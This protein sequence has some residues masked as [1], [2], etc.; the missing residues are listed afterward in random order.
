MP[1]KGTPPT[2]HFA[3]FE[4]ARGKDGY[5]RTGSDKKNTSLKRSQIGIDSR[6]LVN[7]GSAERVIQVGACATPWGEQQMPDDP[8]VPDPERI[9]TQADFGRELTALRER[10]GLKIR[11]V[12]KAAK[13]PVSTVGDYFSGR[14]L[15]ADRQT[16]LRILQVCGE[17]DAGRIAQWEAALA[18][19]RRPPGRRTNNPY[20]GLARFEPEDAGRFFGREDVTELLVSL[21]AESSTVPLMLVGPSGAGKSSLLRAGLLPRLKALAEAAPGIAGPVTVFEP[22]AAPLEDLKVHLAELGPDGDDAGRPAVIVD[23]FEAVFTLCADEAQRRDFVSELCDLA[24]STLVVLALRADFYDHAIRYPGLA[25]ALQSR[26]VV[27]GPMTAEQVHR[28]VTEPARLARVTA[29]DGLVGLL[30]ADL[31]PQGAA[32]AYEPGALPLLSHAMMATWEHSRGGTLAIADYLASGGIKDALTQTAERAYGSLSAEQQQLARRLFLR[33]VH[34]ADDLPPSRAT[35]ELGELREWGGRTDGDAERVL[36]TFVGERMITVDAGTAQISHDALLTA[37]PRLRSWIDSGMEGL[38]TRRRITQGARTWD[39]TGRES[40]ALW[41]G[42]QL[43]IAREWTADEHNRSSLPA[44]AAE[45]VDASIAEEGVR[46]HAER[47]RARRLQAVVAMLS[48][49]LVVVAGLVVYVFQQR[50]AVTNAQHLTSAGEGALE[51]DQIRGQDPSLAAQLSVSVYGLVHTEFATTSLLESS[52]APSAARIVD[53]TG[54]VQWA[55]LSPDHKMLAAAGADGTLRLWDVASPGHPFLV[56]NLVAA[57]ADDPLYVTAFSPDGKVLAAAGAG[58]VVN[59]WDMSDPARPRPLGTLTG[60]KNTIYSVAFSPDGTTL[61]AASADGTVRLWD[62]SDPAHAEPLGR[63]LAVSAASGYVE[64]VQFSPDGET[65]AAGTG[66][67]NVWLWNVTSLAHPV[68][69][70]GMPLTGPTMQVSGVAFSPDGRLLAVSSQ[71]KKVWLWRLGAGGLGGAGS[72]GSAVPDGTLTGA[73]NWVDAVAFSPDGRSLAAG[74]SDA[75]VLVWNV[76]TR[77]VSQ[78]LPAAQPVT[79]VTWDGPERIVSTDAE[80]T[81]LLWSLPTPVLATDNAPSSVAYSPDGK[82]LAVG[83][84]NVQIWNTASRELVATHQLPANVFVNGLAYSPNGAVIASAYN[85]G[86]TAL[87]DAKTLAPLGTP[88]TVT[89]FGNAE[90]VAFSPDGK[91]LAT[92]AD[93]GTVRLWSVT[94][95]ARPREL[96]SVRDSGTYVYTVE[97]APDGKTLAAASTDNYTRLWNVANPADPVR[98]GK[99]L[100]GFTSYAIGVAFSPDSRT[101]AIGSADKT[102]RLWNVSDPALPSLIGA[103]LTGPTGYVWGLAFSPDGSTLAA[104]ITDGSVWLWNVSDPA[105]PTPLANLAGPAGHVYSV[106]FAPAGGQLAAS[107]DDGTVHLWDVSPAAARAEACGNLGQPLTRTEWAA[108]VPG[109]PYRAPCS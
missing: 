83:G 23:Q 40:A 107:S 57:N 10:A 6:F 35:V 7:F 42:S 79:S 88:F 22:T 94:D 67:G 21:A 89:K 93:D 30:L 76:A 33:L 3:R 60:A 28:A 38:R 96:K 105:S 53:S 31:A 102:I 50:Q 91:T 39:H 27:L 87:L 86:T 29:E 98:L 103:P 20:R 72:A 17:T 46:R 47:R 49:L 13:I 62:V 43:A 109:V 34:V 18:R 14:H 80:G 78:T 85:N 9:A 58:Q 16:L 65:L 36:A 77:A 63:P 104:G 84:Q 61:A 100:G 15:P 32:A 59:L 69:F 99:P 108:Y 12:A 66:A 56:D 81:I 25:T 8:D 48:A 2:W 51:A 41:R 26:Q 4:R 44:L 64:S 95:P 68:E 1:P 73:K 5:V 70:A 74:T 106:A 52:G 55:A 45:F 75:S 82:T 54:I 101:L 37:W 92:G 97:F 71:D 19:A 24:H 90:T 11:D